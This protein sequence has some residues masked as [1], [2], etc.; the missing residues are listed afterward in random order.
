MKDPL[1]KHF[2]FDVIRQRMNGYI[3]CTILIIIIIFSCVC[4]NSK[5]IFHSVQTVGLTVKPDVQIYVYEDLLTSDEWISIEQAINDASELTSTSFSVITDYNIKENTNGVIITPWRNLTEC[6][7]EKPVSSELIYTMCSHNPFYDGIHSSGSFDMCAL[8]ASINSK[9]NWNTWRPDIIV[10]VTHASK[11]RYI[12]IAQSFSENVCDQGCAPTL[13]IVESVQESKKHITSGESNFALLLLT[14]KALEDAIQDKKWF[15]NHNTKLVFIGELD[16]S[17]LL[18]IKEASIPFAEL[19]PYHDM[20]NAYCSICNISNSKKYRHP[21]VEKEVSQKFSPWKNIGIVIILKNKNIATWDHYLA[22][23]IGKNSNYVSHTG[24]IKTVE[25]K[26]GK[27][28]MN[29]TEEEYDG[30]FNGSFIN[31]SLYQK[32]K[33]DTKRNKYNYVVAMKDGTHV[34]LPEMSQLKTGDFIQLP[35]TMEHA[36]VLLFDSKFV[37]SSNKSKFIQ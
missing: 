20:F 3:L 32:V 17:T 33:N 1:W 12:H 9:A 29:K 34:S 36:E 7:F 13:E 16:D 30:C 26:D 5:N 23:N 10:A 27:K 14:R 35:G 6:T 31:L 24:E 11:P 28:I 2:F 4:Y 25:I 8:R 22:T 37:Y 19:F 18:K 15:M 21:T